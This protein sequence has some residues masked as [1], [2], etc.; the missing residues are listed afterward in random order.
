MSRPMDADGT[1]RYSTASPGRENAAAVPATPRTPTTAHTSAATNAAVI[2][3]FTL[4]PNALDPVTD[5]LR[6]TISGNPQQR[7]RC[8]PARDETAFPP[9]GMPLAHGCDMNRVERRG[10]S[11]WR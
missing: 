2:S 6:H 10:Y 1:I 8:R 11:Q 4:V 9:R 5:S 7:V 3:F